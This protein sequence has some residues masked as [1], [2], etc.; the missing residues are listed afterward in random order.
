VRGFFRTVQFI[1][2]ELYYDRKLN[3]NTPTLK[4]NLKSTDDASD[5]HD[6][7]GNAPGSFLF[8]LQAIKFVPVKLSETHL[9]DIGCGTGKILCSA[10]SIG[11]KKVSGIDL[12]EMGLKLAKLNCA[13]TK[14]RY[15]GGEYEIINTDA[16]HYLIPESVSVIFMYNPFGAETMR[17]VIENIKKS[18]KNKLRPVWIIYQNPSCEAEFINAGFISVK[19]IA[20]KNFI[21][22]SVLKI[23]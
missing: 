1:F 22:L 11:I 13:K 23:G 19:R 18:I 8:F 6:S 3:I 12:D 16:A 2:L 4:E 10:I 20:S 21:D 5:K 15:N 9:L 7:H 14:S 17:L